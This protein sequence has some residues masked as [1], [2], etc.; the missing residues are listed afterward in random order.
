MTTKKLTRC[1]ACWA[2]FLSE[3]NFDISYTPG[4][5]NQKADLL[6]RHS[7]N[8]SS[9]DNVNRQQYLLQTILLAKRLEIILIERE[10]N[11]TI[12]D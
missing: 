4:K 1:H 2:K 10:N 6:T 8:L 12:I 5:E 7:N 3:F 11:N 9:D